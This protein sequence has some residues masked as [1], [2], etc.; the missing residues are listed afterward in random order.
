[1]SK[2]SGTREFF[3]GILSNA[4]WEWIKN[5]LGGPTM[6][7]TAVALWGKFKHGSLD[8]FAIGGMFL[9]SLVLILLSH[10]R[11]RSSES[12]PIPPTPTG[13]T[14][15]QDAD[16]ARRMEVQRKADLWRAQESRRICDE[17]RREALKKLEEARSK[18]AVFTP[19]QW[20]AFRVAKDLRV[21]L[22]D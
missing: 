8:W 5:N 13:V 18:L 14:D 2:N 3:A 17:E 7:A 11:T 1:M 10:R 16:Q 22:G 9:L 4:A 19:L 21:L 12:L 20:E 15:E 6:M